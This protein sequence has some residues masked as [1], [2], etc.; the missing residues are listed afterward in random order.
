M[1]G[2]IILVTL[3]AI[4]AVTSISYATDV[5]GDVWG[6]WSSAGN[7]YNVVGDLRVPPGSTLVIGPGCYI[8]FQGYYQFLVDNSAIL[9][10][11]G[12]ESDSIIFTGGDFQYQW[13]GINFLYAD[14]GSQISYC[15]IENGHGTGWDDGGGIYCDNSYLEVKNSLI[16]TNSA[17]FGSAI[18][19]N[20]NNNI[21]IED[22]HIENNS[23]N[24][25]I[26]STS[27][28]QVEII[29]NTFTNNNSTTVISTADG[30]DAMS[31]SENIF[32][33][34]HNSLI[35]WID[36][37]TTIVEGNIIYNNTGE[38]F[39]LWLSA[40]VFRHNIIYNNY[41][42]GNTWGAIFLS[43][44][45]QYL[46]ENNTIC[47]NSGEYG[48]YLGYIF[49]E[50]GTNSPVEF[51]NNIIWG[52]SFR[53]PSDSLF[54]LEYVIF[55]QIYSD[56]QGGWSGIGNI[57]ADPMFVDSAN[58]DFHLLPGS[59]CIDAGDPASPYDPDS[60]IADMGALYFDQTVGIKLPDLLP[61]EITLHQNYPNPFNAGTVIKFELSN[62]SR[63]SIDIYDILGRKVSSVVDAYYQPGSYE[64][65][66]N[67]Q[68]SFGKELPSGIYLYKLRSDT[69][70]QT[71]RMILLK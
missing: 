30:N 12:T 6:E 32:F 31:I 20:E 4:C 14:S 65:G 19:L 8:E 45:S 68:S 11:N 26:Y 38:I 33:D 66:W 5:S 40:A 17:S 41:S 57:M 71:R 44:D 42:P 13:D 61:R 55:T 15:R 47:N 51:K 50:H 69:F 24:A 29:G 63:V 58:G 35:I 34:N 9:Q 49:E 43:E 52:N 10:A 22:N 27:N 36:G 7:P 2:R 21:I 3:F 56:I 23:G 67:G 39:T 46:V 28:T 48:T 37:W 60:T 70:D 25:T 53:N 54:R 16:T 64:I 62:E 18:Y 59:P 1:I